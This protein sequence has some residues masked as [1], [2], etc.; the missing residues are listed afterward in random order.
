MVAVPAVPA[1]RVVTKIVPTVAAS[2]A[3]LCQGVVGG[4][5]CVGHCALPFLHDGI[6]PPMGI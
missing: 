1:V 4:V 6:I 3:V 2:L 5:V